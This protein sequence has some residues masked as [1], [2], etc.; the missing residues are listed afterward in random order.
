MISKWNKLQGTQ[1]GWSGLKVCC[2]DQA[3]L[4]STG[5]GKRTLFWQT[6]QAGQGWSSTGRLHSWPSQHKHSRRKAVGEWRAMGR[7][8]VGPLFFHLCTSE[9]ARIPGQREAAGV[10]PTWKN[11]QPEQERVLDRSTRVWLAVS[12]HFFDGAASSAQVFGKSILHC[13]T[14]Q[15]SRPWNKSSADKKCKDCKT[16]NRKAFVNKQTSERLPA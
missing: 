3:A 10:H 12:L 8:S 1:I 2:H 14:A 15:A 4:K 6:E 5:G 11:F 13:S 9:S 16:A 7:C